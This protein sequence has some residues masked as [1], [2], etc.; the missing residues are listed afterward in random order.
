MKTFQMFLC[1][2]H[3]EQ[4][5]LNILGSRWMIFKMDELKR[6]DSFF[7]FGLVGSNSLNKCIFLNQACN[8]PE[9]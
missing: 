9:E 2:L 1:S 5:Y 8:F 7:I 4:I 3:L 6:E